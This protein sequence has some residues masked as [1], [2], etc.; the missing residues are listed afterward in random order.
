MVFGGEVRKRRGP[1]NLNRRRPVLEAAAA[2]PPSDDSNGSKVE[3]YILNI[4]QATRR[5]HP[6]LLDRNNTL[7]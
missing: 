2:V 7:R 5:I 3:D 4:V 6:E 1:G